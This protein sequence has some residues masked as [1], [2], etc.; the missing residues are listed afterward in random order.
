[1]T[2]IASPQASRIPSRA[3]AAT[4]GVAPAGLSPRRIPSVRRLRVSAAA[5]HR[6]LLALHRMPP[7]WQTPGFTSRLDRTRAQLLPI[8]S[9][10]ALADSFCREHGTDDP[11]VRIAYALRW[12]ELSGQ[13]EERPWR[14]HR[15]AVPR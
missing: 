2:V 14:L 8:R 6:L 3:A 13:V 5:I 10:A 4:A 11:V 12:L 15:T 1:M 9:L 7:A